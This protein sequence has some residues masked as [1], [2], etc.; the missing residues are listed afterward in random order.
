MPAGL[1]PPDNGLRRSP[2]LRAQQENE[3]S[4]KRKAHTTFGTSEATKVGLGLFLIV[5]PSTNIKVPEHQTNPKSTLIEQVMNRF[6]KVNNLYDGNLNEVHHLFY[7]TNISS[8]KSF[9]FRNEI[10]HDDKLSFADSM[11]K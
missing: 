4:Q 2:H 8:N 11:E 1:N 7:A 3:D 9:T 6:H 5:A 10:K